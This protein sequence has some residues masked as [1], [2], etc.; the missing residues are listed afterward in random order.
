MRIAYRLR[1]VP[2][3]SEWGREDNQLTEGRRGGGGIELRGDSES[4]DVSH[5]ECT[6]LCTQNSLMMSL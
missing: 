6:V 2:K 3:L 5:R 4:V 1:T